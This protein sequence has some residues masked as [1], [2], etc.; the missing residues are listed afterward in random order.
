LFVLKSLIIVALL[1]IVSE[2][3]DM[4]DGKMTKE[5]ARTRDVAEAF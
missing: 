3:S 5:Q 1:L 4:A 2:L